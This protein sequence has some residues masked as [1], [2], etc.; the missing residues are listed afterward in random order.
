MRD[1]AWLHANRAGYLANLGREAAATKTLLGSRTDPI[2]ALQFT[3]L[4]HL[5]EAIKELTMPEQPARFQDLQVQR[6]GGI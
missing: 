4:G 6:W 3:I 2:A 1:Q 5:A